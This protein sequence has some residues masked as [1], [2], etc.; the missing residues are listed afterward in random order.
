MHKET[1]IVTRINWDWGKATKYPIKTIAFSWIPLHQLFFNDTALH[2]PRTLHP[3]EKYRN[4]D[5]SQHGKI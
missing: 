2:L 3:Q 1:T 5:L 4:M